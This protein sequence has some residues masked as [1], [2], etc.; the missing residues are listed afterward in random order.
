[1]I[2]DNYVSLVGRLTKDIEVK[3]TNTGLSYARFSVA[4]NRPKTKDSQE[5][6]A[7]F[8]PCVAWSNVADFLGKYGTKGIQIQIKGSIRTGSYEKN[9]QKIY[10]T[11]VLVQSS[12]IQS[13]VSKNNGRPSKGNKSYYLNDMKSDPAINE[14]FEDDAIVDFSSDDL[15][16]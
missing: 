10:T 3:K 2:E 8:V 7:D 6:Q 11:E 4:V 9:G 1:M 14:S 5:Q 15:P 13:S 12:N 16:F